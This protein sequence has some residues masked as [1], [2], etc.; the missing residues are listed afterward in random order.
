MAHTKEK[1][2]NNNK[3]AE[4]KQ[5]NS[6]CLKQ[7]QAL[8]LLQLHAKILKLIMLPFHKKLKEFQT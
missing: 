3:K 4:N 8:L 1:Q 6:N 7:F 5:K 2:T